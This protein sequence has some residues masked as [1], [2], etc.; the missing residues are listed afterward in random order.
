MKWPCEPVC[1]RSVAL[2]ALEALILIAAAGLLAAIAA[3]VIR[4][5]DE[6]AR[7]RQDQKNARELASAFWSGKQAGVTSFVFGVSGN[8]HPSLETV[9]EEVVL[10]GT[11]STGFWRGRY[12]G[13]PKLSQADLEAAA[14]YLRW[15]P[16]KAALIYTGPPAATPAE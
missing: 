11:P 15:E 5:P 7:L 8:P 10:G 6:E 12:F 13:L 14:Q 3:P 9:V 16:G 2:S 4:G 1:S